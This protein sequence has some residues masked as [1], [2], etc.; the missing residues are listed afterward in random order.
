MSESPR[1]KTAP[2]IFP[3]IIGAILLLLVFSFLLWG[4]FGGNIT[5]FF[6][7]GSILPLSPYLDPDLTSIF[8]GELGYDGQQFLTIALDPGLQEPES[9][10][11]L[12]H[13][14]YRYRRIFYPLLGYILGLGNHNLIPYMMVAINLVSI[15]LLMGAISAYFYSD[16]QRRWQSL[17]VLCIP[18][19]WMSFSLSTADILSSLFLVIALYGYAARKPRWVGISLSLGSLTR[20]TIL[21][22]WLGIAWASI[23]DRRKDLIWPLALSPI[24]FL[25]WNLYVRTRDLPGESGAI[26]NLGLPL[27][28]IWQKVL[29]LMAGGLTPKNAYEMLQFGL[30]LAIAA[31]IFWVHYRYPQSNR[32]IYCCTVLVCSVLVLTTTM[33]L[34]YYLNYARVFTDLYLLLLLSLDPLGFSIRK[35]LFGLGGLLS[36]IFL[37]VHS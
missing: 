33:S 28:G 5:G 1:K 36:L 9:I 6:R 21:L 26:G 23:R 7:I 19:L 13:P 15:L 14:T 24:P 18:G 30:L 10:A 20:E 27:R 35:G 22:A 25:F 12:D 31:T 11:A 2:V 37:A 34:N 3:I 16:L 17:L 4:K 8:S 29:M 32:A